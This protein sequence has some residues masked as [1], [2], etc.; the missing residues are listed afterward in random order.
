MDS[1]KADEILRR[2]EKLSERRYLP[3]IVADRGR[4]LVDQIRNFRPKRILEGGTFIGYS[5]IL[6]GKELESGSDCF[7]MALRLSR[8]EPLCGGIMKF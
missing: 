5:T 6:M 1:S 3:I 7:L 2:I 8:K 4:I